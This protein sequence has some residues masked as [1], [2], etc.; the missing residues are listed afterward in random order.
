[1]T[2]RPAASE[3]LTSLQSSLR[4]RVQTSWRLPVG[5][6]RLL[7]SPI[8]TSEATKSTW[9]P[10]TGSARCCGLYTLCFQCHCFMHLTLS[11]IN[12]TLQD[13]AVTPAAFIKP[14]NIES[15]L[16]DEAI[17][18]TLASID[19]QAQYNWVSKTIMCRCL[20][21][22]TY[23]KHRGVTPFVEHLGGCSRSRPAL[24]EVY[25]SFISISYR[26]LNASLLGFP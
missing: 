24:H 1:M 8:V 16:D 14:T 19:P 15:N 21:E 22:I 23:D 11:Q 5:A 10:A 17:M 20:Q 13:L 18:G 7:E 3:K 25:P 12:R 26:K 2:P 4:K 6:L 9:S